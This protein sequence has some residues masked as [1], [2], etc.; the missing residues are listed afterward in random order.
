MTNVSIFLPDYVEEVDDEQLDLGKAIALHLLPGAA[1]MLTYIILAWVLRPFSLPS[2]LPFLFAIPIT[3]I[4]VEL[5]YLLYQGK[6]RNGRYSLEGIV[7]Y[8]QPLTIKKFTGYTLLTLIGML[9]LFLLLG[10]TD[11]FMLQYF[12]AWWPAWLM[13]DYATLMQGSTTLLIVGIILTMLL[14]NLV[15]PAIEELYFRGYLLPRMARYDRWGF[16][17][18]GALFAVYHFWSPWSVFS[19]AIAVLPLGIAARKGNV[20]VS[21]AAHCL[22]NT[23]GFLLVMPMLLGQ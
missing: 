7:L 17:L 18:N 14:A 23:L 4:P 19:R 6:Q 10:F 21:V 20:Y 11:S 15:A 8:R 1:I 9:A 12:F 16:I 3:L 2:L 5:G 22:I 13:P